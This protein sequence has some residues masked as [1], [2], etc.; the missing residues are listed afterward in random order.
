MPSGPAWSFSAEQMSRRQGK[1]AWS[2]VITGDAI[3][4]TMTWTKKNGAIFHYAFEGKK[5]AAA[6]AS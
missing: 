4:G 5:A 3:A 1:T 2:G 6:N